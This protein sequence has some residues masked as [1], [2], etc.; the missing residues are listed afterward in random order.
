[1]NDMDERF[2]I[3]VEIILKHEGGYVHDPDDLGG[4]TNMGITKRRYKNEDIKNMTVARAKELYFHDFYKPLGLHFV[5][6]DLLALHVFDMAVN[7][8]RKTAVLLLQDLLPG[9][10]SDGKIGPITAQALYY[11]ESS[12]DMVAA[13]IAKRYERY[14]TVSTY[15]NN[16]KFLKG[17]INRVKKTELS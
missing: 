9:V 1:M 5:K 8:G 3:F 4:E 12:V 11:A 16:K 13:Y 14:Y 15:R 2:N 6:N 17:W 7:A 10:E